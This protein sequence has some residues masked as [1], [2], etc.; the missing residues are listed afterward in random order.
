MRGCRVTRL[1]LG[2]FLLDIKSFK[3]I[4]VTHIGS[5]E[6]VYLYLHLVEF[7]DKFKCG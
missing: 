4:F 2:S 6:L 5:I 3:E 1:A 7:Y